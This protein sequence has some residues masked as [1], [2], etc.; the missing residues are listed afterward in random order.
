M[1]V[2]VYVNVSVCVCVYLHMYVNVYGN[3]SDVSVYRCKGVSH[4]YAYVNA[5]ATCNVNAKFRQMQWNEYK[6]MCICPYVGGRCMDWCMYVC[7]YVRNYKRVYV[8]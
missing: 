4:A 3:V 2:H 6:Y 7:M 1:H 8:M 5:Y